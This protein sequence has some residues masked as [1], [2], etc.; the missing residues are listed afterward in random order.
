VTRREHAKEDAMVRGRDESRPTQGPDPSGVTTESRTQEPGATREIPRERSGPSRR[1]RVVA[2]QRAV[3]LVGVRGGVSA[4]AILTGVLVAFG[5]MFL[6]SGVAGVLVA[7]DVLDEGVD[8]TQAIEVGV[9]AGIALVVTQLLAYMWGGYTAGRMGRGAGIGNGLAV[10]LV[11]ILLALI[12]GAVVAA[13]GATAQFNLPF[14][15]ARLPVEDDFLID[16]GVGIG[17]AS[18]VAM[19]LGGAIG[20]ALGSRWHTKLERRAEEEEIAHREAERR[21]ID[22]RDRDARTEPERAGAVRR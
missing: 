15:D 22:V 11:A 19:F 6:L 12:V 3:P 5:A 10:P 8:S 7:L 14:S 20:G 9:G 13:L 16:F 18:L 1:D 17:I 2:R 21:E 4:G